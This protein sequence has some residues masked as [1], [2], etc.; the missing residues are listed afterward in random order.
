MG[1]GKIRL[2]D[3]PQTVDVMVHRYQ[4]RMFIASASSIS[5]TA[6]DIPED[7]ESFPIA[8]AKWHFLT[9]KQETRGQQATTWLSLVQ[10]SLR[11]MLADQNAIPDED[12]VFTPGYATLSVRG[13]DNSTR[14]VDWNT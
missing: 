12:L 9:D 2:L 8:W 7:Y 6:I 5:T 11:T 13:G 1:R 4:R 3:A 10:E 14:Y